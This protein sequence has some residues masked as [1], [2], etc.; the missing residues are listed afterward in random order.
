MIENKQRGHQKHARLIA[1]HVFGG[2]VLF[3]SV[4]FAAGFLNALCF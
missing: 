2:R 1:G 4:R 3:S